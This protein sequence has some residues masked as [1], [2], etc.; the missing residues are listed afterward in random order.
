MSDSVTERKDALAELEPLQR[1]DFLGLF[2]AMDG[3]PV[4]IRLVDPPLHEFLP[5]FEQLSERITDAKIRL[6]AAGSLS[7]VDSLL[8]RLR[9]DEDVLRQVRAL[10]ESNPMLGLRGVRLAIRHPEILQMQTRAIFHAAC[11][12]VEAGCQP[13]PEVMVPLTCDVAELIRVREV[14]ESEAEAVFSD[15]QLRVGYRIGT[16]IETPRAAL[17]AAGYTEH[18]DFFSVGSNDLTQMTYGLSRDDAETSFLLDYLRTEVFDHDPFT[19]IDPEGVGALIDS[20]VRA[21]GQA[22]HP[23]EIGVCGEHGGDPTSI[24]WCH[25]HG[26]SYVSC[27]P[28]RIPVARLAAAQAALVSQS[29]S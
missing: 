8:A 25:Q 22:E 14:I 29:P 16:M 3:L 18:A 21:A 7:E 20:A 12:A 6:S 13:Q 28:F 4:I 15:R 10:H 5:T 19:S 17:L 1:A 23:I 2:Q 26:L 9:S 24:A 11:D 27:S